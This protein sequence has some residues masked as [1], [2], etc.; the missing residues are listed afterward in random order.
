LFP[1]V[2]RLV[3][4]YVRT[5]VDFQ[6]QNACELGLQK[7][8]ERII[9]RL[10]DAILPD[11]D[12]GELPLM[13]ILNRHQPA[14]ST[15]DVSFKT[16]RTCYPTQKSHINQAVL[17]TLSWEGSATF[18]LEQSPVVRSY[19]RN[20]QLGLTVPYEYQGVAHVYEPD[21]LVKL[22]NGLNVLLEVKGFEDDQTKAKHTAA[23]RWASAV[24][25]WGG[26][27]RWRFHVC[28]NPQLLGAELAA[29]VASTAA[30]AG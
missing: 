28:R 30:A 15:A 27:G 17:D 18:R 3:D 4:E 13:P 8:V 24:N 16:T 25:H 29:L 6:G 26:L 11:D 9:G 2:Y 23:R 19:A 5:K 22:V 1:Q 20:D 12:A 7:Y 21:F 10:R 14:G